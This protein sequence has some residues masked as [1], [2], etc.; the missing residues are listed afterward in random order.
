MQNNLICPKPNNLKIVL[1]TGVM[2]IKRVLGIKNTVS[3]K[4]NIG[5][6]HLV[7]EFTKLGNPRY[8]I[9]LYKK[10]TKRYVIKTWYSKVRDLD[11][12]SLINEYIVNGIFD[13]KNVKNRSEIF[14]PGSVELISGNHSLSA[15]F[16]Y[17]PGKK[18][19]E[20]PI[21]F[22][23]K[24]LEEVIGRLTVLSSHLTPT[25]LSNLDTRGFW[26]Y[27]I[28]LIPLTLT[29][30]IKSD[31][32]RT[33]LKSFFLCILG[34][35]TD[36]NNQLHLAH[37]D[38]NCENI[39]LRGNHIYLLDAERMVLTLPQYDTAYILQNPEMNY[40]KNR[41]NFFEVTTNK[42]LWN[43]ISLQFALSWLSFES[44]D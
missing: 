39:I 16:E 20:Y 11:Y 1:G 4:K 10:G 18:L 15:V 24:T 26:F 8:A 28:T 32:K 36:K 23:L 19:S 29:A 22:Q 14:F 41:V 7:K 31:K 35:V 13:K 21:Q 42:F 43:Y 12:Y 9:G 40:L 5:K 33:I 27:L 6:Y 38:L 44:E 37:R 30:L 34:V 25:Q 2:V 17:I 3:I